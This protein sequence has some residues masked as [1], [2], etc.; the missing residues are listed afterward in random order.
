MLQTKNSFLEIGSVWLIGVPLVF[1]GAL[2]LALPVYFVV[3]MA[4][5]EEIV[6]GI[7]CWRRF[8]SK[9]WLNNL[10]SGF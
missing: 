1:L 9:K 4:Q 8:R 6:K 10:I 5:A 7:L 3:L 2:Y